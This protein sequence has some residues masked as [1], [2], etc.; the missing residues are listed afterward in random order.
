MVHG[1]RIRVIDRAVDHVGV[2]DP[3]VIAELARPRVG[4]HFTPYAWNADRL[5]L[6]PGTL[7]SI[8]TATNAA[9]SSAGARSISSMPCHCRFRRWLKRPNHEIALR[10]PA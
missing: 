8:G 3:G 7:R 5:F 9:A 1:R 2:E 4:Q 10:A 6:G